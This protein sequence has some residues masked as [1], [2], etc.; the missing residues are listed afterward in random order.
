MY[1]YKIY[2]R[3]AFFP[4]TNMKTLQKRSCCHGNNNVSERIISNKPEPA[5]FA[6]DRKF[7]N[8]YT[9]ALNKNSTQIKI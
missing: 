4:R 6:P 9:G 2:Q 8:F 1:T 5:A 3:D 7:I